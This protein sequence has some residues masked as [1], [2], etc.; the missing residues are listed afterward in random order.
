LSKR[1]SKLQALRAHRAALVRRAKKAE[2]IGDEESVE[3]TRLLL[4]QCD[5]LIEMAEKA[6]GPYGS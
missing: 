4:R 6:V 5:C 3:M 1:L 2:Q